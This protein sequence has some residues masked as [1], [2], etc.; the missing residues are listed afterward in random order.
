[1][2]RWK[3]EKCGNTVEGERPVHCPKCGALAF[4]IVIDPEWIREI[5]SEV[6]ED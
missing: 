2:V 6:V 1:M 3:C 4:D 5:Q